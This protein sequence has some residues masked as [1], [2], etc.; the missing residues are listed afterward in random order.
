[1][2]FLL[3]EKFE[4]PLML[5]ARTVIALRDGND[6]LHHRLPAYKTPNLAL[7]AQAR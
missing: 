7:N 5:I 2:L 3:I 1:M 4:A 6:R